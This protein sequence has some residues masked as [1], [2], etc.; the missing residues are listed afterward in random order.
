MAVAG[1]A[2]ERHTDS[3][4]SGLSHTGRSSSIHRDEAAYYDAGPGGDAIL[5]WC[6]GEV[7]GSAVADS[8]WELV[9][10]AGL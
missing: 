10:P 5:A 1:F 6:R 7:R 9:N 3:R 2:E 4:R 8:G